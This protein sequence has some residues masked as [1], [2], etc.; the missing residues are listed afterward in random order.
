MKIKNTTDYPDH[1]LR[2]MTA[3]CCR[4]LEFRVGEVKLAVFRNR[5]RRG[6]R[7]F[8]DYTRRMI[9]CTVHRTDGWPRPD[10]RPGMHGE[11]LADRLEVLVNLTS[12]ELYHLAAKFDADHRQRT[13]G[14]GTRHASGERETR[15]ASVLVLRAFREQRD[16]LVAEWSQ[17]PARE[18][19]P[20][21][22]L[23]QQRAA[24]AAAQLAAWERRAKIA[25]NKVRRYRKQVRY[26]EQALATAA[27]RSPSP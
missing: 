4:Q 8:A 27:T 24:K 3:W 1:F 18:S 21:P 14:A 5:S 25:A 20:R 26:Y 13:R 22:T 10:N 7:G 19:K 16:A 6:Y 15:H 2:R 9:S 11:A 23:Q 17:P 12:H